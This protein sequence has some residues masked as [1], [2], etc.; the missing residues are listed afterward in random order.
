MDVAARADV[1]IATASR[2][3]NNKL[4]QIAITEKTRERVLKAARELNYRPNRFARNLRMG[5]AL[6]HLLFVVSKA[7]GSHFIQHPFLSHMI[8]AIQSEAS[9]NGYYL[10]FLSVDAADWSPFTG[11]LADNTGGVITWGPIGPEVYRLITHRRVPLVAIEPYGERPEPY[12]CV[13]VDNDMAVRQA[14]EHLVGLGHSRIAI[15]SRSNNGL[16]QFRERCEV[17]R[18]CCSQQKRRIRTYEVLDAPPLSE[19]DWTK[20][21]RGQK[22]IAGW[23]SIP[24]SDRPTAVVAVNDLLALAALRILQREGILIPRDMS[25]VGI[26]DIEW[27]RYNEPPLTTVRI[28]QDEMGKTAVDLMM[29]LLGLETQDRTRLIRTRLIVRNTTGPAPSV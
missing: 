27:A 9:R 17:F 4:G 3:L 10:S 23:A 15:I 16:P 5:V 28:P 7:S 29:E 8:D 2:V 22:A 13:Y 14:I 19:L 24:Q 18:D 20:P 25:I 1:S 11:I 26:D 6:R 12:L 21:S